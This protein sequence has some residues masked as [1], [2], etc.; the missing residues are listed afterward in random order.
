MT[1]GKYS[2]LLAMG[3]PSKASSAS[4]LSLLRA[5]TD[6]YKEKAKQQFQAFDKI[7]C[8]QNILKPSSEPETKET[9]NN[10]RAMAKRNLEFAVNYV[11]ALVKEAVVADAKRRY[12]HQHW[13]EEAR[14]CIVNTTRE[15]AQ[16]SA[17]TEASL[18]RVLS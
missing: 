15:L 10:R 14:L 2:G 1:V 5:V 3:L 17:I 12:V 11:H 13:D 6:S 9:L 4:W 7:L 16:P 8:T 18:H